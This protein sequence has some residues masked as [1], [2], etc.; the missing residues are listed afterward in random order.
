M[1]RKHADRAAKKSHGPANKERLA[2][3]QQIA[4]KKILV[5][6]LFDKFD[7][8]FSKNLDFEEMKNFLQEYSV[9]RAQNEAEAKAK[10]EAEVGRQTPDEFEKMKAAETKVIDTAP[11]PEVTDDAVRYVMLVVNGIS[12]SGEITRAD[13]VVAV[14]TWESLA[15]DQAKITKRFEKFDVDKSGGLSPDQVKEMLKWMNGGDAVTQEEVDWVV[16]QADANGDGILQKNEINAASAVWYSR[17][18]E[19]ED[20]NGTV[21]IAGPE[22]SCACTIL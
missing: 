14:S 6:S 12:S 2:K 17:V 3:Q 9:T 20:A 7:T 4:E 11:P 8:D 13:V 15:S 21:G 22:A 16:K 19:Q 18:L 5:Q 1:A 10:A